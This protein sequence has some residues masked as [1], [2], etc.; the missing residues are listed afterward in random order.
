MVDTAAFD[1]REGYYICT[2]VSGGAIGQGCSSDLRTHGTSVCLK[3]IDGSYRF[4][5]SMPSTQFLNHL[6]VSLPLVIVIP[7]TTFLFASP[8][9][10]AVSS[11][12]TTINVNVSCNSRDSLGCHALFS[13]KYLMNAR[14]GTWGSCYAP[15]LASLPRY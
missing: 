13:G 3:A 2:A 11:G 7:L 1:I 12:L 14:W 4:S 9:F 8:T 6:P 15:L 10:F 5:S